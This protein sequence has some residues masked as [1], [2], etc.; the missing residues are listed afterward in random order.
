MFEASTHVGVDAYLLAQQFNSLLT[1]VVS[2]QMST[3]ACLAAIPSTDKALQDLG[4]FA[5]VDL[6]L[7]SAGGRKSQASKDILRLIASMEE[8]HTKVQGMIASTHL[9]TAL[10]Y[11]VS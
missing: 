9:S 2:L 11:D 8:I 1:S 5:F 4:R 3:R 6:H 7:L 10:H